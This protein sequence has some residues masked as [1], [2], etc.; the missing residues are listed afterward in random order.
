MRFHS[1]ARIANSVFRRTL[2]DK[3]PG[4]QRIIPAPGLIARPALAAR[5]T[6]RDYGTDDKNSNAGSPPALCRGKRR[7]D[8]YGV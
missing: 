3:Q 1:T 2:H 4:V 8:D 6:V 5:I 7:L